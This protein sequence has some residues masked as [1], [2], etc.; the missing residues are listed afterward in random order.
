MARINRNSP[1]AD[2]YNRHLRMTV[3]IQ[4]LVSGEITESERVSVVF[5]TWADAILKA[6]FEGRKQVT[7]PKNFEDQDEFETETQTSCEAVKEYVENL[8]WSINFQWEYPN[9]GFVIKFSK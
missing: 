8:G 2:L 5:E 9:R 7:V 1:C 3:T 6:A 4:K